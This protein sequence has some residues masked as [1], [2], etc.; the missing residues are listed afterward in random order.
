[1]PHLS[2]KKLS[3]ELQ[4]ELFTQLQSVVASARSETAGKIIDELLTETEYQM[5]SKRLAAAVM[6]DVGCSAYQVWNTLAISPSTAA[7]LQV[8]YEAGAYRQ[9][10]KSLH[11]SQRHEIWLFLEK[12]SRGGLPEMG[13]NRWSG[14][15]KN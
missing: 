13:K 14:I 12:L 11:K 3:Q 6:F 15:T 9:T 2:T 4:T 10:L 8:A 7:R 5:L 1:M